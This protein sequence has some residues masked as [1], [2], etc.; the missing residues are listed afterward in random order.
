MIDIRRRRQALDLLARV[1]LD[2]GDDMWMKDL[3]YPA[4]KNPTQGGDR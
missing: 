1:L 4:G 3:G 2:P